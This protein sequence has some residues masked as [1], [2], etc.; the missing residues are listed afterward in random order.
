MR[1]FALAVALLMIPVPSVAQ[2]AAKDASPAATAQA[3]ADAAVD[4][5]KAGNNALAVELSSKALA[6]YVTVNALYIRGTAYGNAQDYSKAILDLEKAKLQATAGKADVATLNAIDASLT[7]VYLFG[8]QVQKGLALGADLKRRDPANTRVDDSFF[9]YFV[10]Q[11]AAA[12]KA[13]HVEEAVADLESGA[14]TVPARAVPLYV[15]AANVLSAGANPDWKRV[16]AEVDKALA[17]NANDAGANY[18]AGIALANARDP[19]G[20]IELL[21]RAKANAGTDASLNA[22]I[23]AALK[24][25]GG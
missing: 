17:I 13:G 5:L 6:L 23:D 3:Y 15:Q 1:V 8:G 14:K 20:A 11:S 19:K 2:T 10:L 16:K 9:G 7:T 4:A 22:D 25:L 24:Q 21:R 18:V 12:M